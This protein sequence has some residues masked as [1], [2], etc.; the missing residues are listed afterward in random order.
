MTTKLLSTI[1][2]FSM[3]V[4]TAIAQKDTHDLPGAA[5]SA[6]AEAEAL[7]PAQGACTGIVLGNLARTTAVSGR[8]AEAER[9]AEQSIEFFVAGPDFGD[10]L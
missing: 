4:A 7:L 9:L 1:A 3:S 2:M 6:L 8:I 5:C 10:V